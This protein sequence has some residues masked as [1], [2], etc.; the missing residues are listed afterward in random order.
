[1][2]AY[3]VPQSSECADGVKNSFDKYGNDV[4][5]KI[6]FTDASLSFGTTNLCVQVAKMKDAGVDFVTTCMDTNGVVTLAKEMKKQ[7]LDATQ[8]LPN[9]YDDE[10]HRRVRRPVRGLVSCAPIFAPFEIP[11]DEPPGPEEVPRVDEEVG[12]EPS[13]N[14][15][16]GW[17]NADLFVD[18][19]KDAGPQLRPAEADRRHQQHDRLDRRRHACRTSTGPSSTRTMTPNAAATCTVEDRGRR[20]SCRPCPEAG[21]PFI[22]VDDAADPATKTYYR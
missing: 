21:K 15:V 4:G 12:R 10:H 16:A 17:L 3:N 20:S 5:A 11:E 22:C 7:S 13:E 9:G 1:M 8:Y 6:V 19:L 2:L 14:S 18:G